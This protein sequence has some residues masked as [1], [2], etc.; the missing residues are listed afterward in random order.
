MVES[1]LRIEGVVAWDWLFQKFS[2]AVES[3]TTYCSSVELLF[4]TQL[5]A[6]KRAMTQQTD[7]AMG[8]YIIYTLDS[9]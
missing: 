3:W 2:I 5:S 8:Q 4:S 1:A 7:T 6:P 9:S